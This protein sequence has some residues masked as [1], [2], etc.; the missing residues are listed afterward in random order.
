MRPVF[1][2]LLLAACS[3]LQTPNPQLQ[4]P[5]FQTPDN[6]L[7]ACSTLSV[8]N[9]S[10]C[11][12]DLDSNDVCDNKDPVVLEK[13][14]ALPPEKK[15]TPTP[16]PPVRVV[17]KPTVVTESLEKIKSVK[18]YSYY[19]NNYHYFVSGNRITLYLPVSVSVGKVEFENFSYPA[20]VNRITFDRSSRTA[21]GECITPKEFVKY[22]VVNVCDRL[23]GIKFDLSYADYATFKTPEDLLVDFKEEYLF[24]TVEKQHVGKRLATLAVFRSNRQNQTLLWIDPLNG[25]PLKYQRVENGKP[26][27]TVE[28]Q[29]LFAE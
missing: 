14:S 9:G 16:A 18:S 13:V 25:L 21:F 24:E 4:I 26:V 15:K 3:Q 7:H 1:L 10:S 19:V 23:A 5:N 22:A 17:R 27:E 12:Q 6:R 28:F 29:D 8:W 2:L 20:M 11:C